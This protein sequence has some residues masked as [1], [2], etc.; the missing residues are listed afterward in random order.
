MIEIFILSIVQGITE[1]LPIS[2]SSHLIL[3]SE[4]LNFENKSLSIDVSLH[5]GSFLAVIT[6]FYKEIINFYKNRILFLKV[7]ISSI[8]LMIVG[9]FLIKTNLIDVLRNIKVIAW[10]TII[11]GFLLYIS[12]R[13]KLTANIQKNFNFK[14]AILIGVFQILSLVPGVSR[15][16]IGITA[17]RFLKFNRRDSTK[18]SFLLSIPILG[19]L[20]VHGIGDI[21][22]SENINL[23]K[24]NLLS[25]FFSF[26]FSLITIK[27][28]LY[29]ISKFDLKIFVYYRIS[30]GLILLYFAYL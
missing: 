30:L 11:F 14:S 5:I 12:D 21:F 24:I 1:F 8:P 19:V 2:S 6:F 7:L 3:I 17:A 9:Y 16:G 27:F 10:T 28:F 22:F 15:S 26:I 4:Y 20:S 23:A 25:I 13:C 18:I 29:Y